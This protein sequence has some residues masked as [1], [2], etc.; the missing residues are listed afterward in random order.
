M[1]VVIPLFGF[2]V[3]GGI[4]LLV[5]LGN[6]LAGRGHDVCFAV[7]SDALESPFPVDASVKV[8]RIRTPM[9][10][11]YLDR[12]CNALLL[13]AR[14]PRCD[15][16]LANAFLTAYPACGAVLLGRARAGA[17]FA[18][19][20]EPLVMGGLSERTAAARKVV[21]A[22]ARLTY[23]LPLAKMAL[24]EWIREQL[25]TRH[26]VESTVVPPFINLEAFRPRKAT[27][28]KWLVATVG[29]GAAWK[30][31][32][33]LYEAM[34]IVRGK[35]PEARL[36]VATREELQVPG[37]VA[38][39]V[40]NPSSDEALAEIYAGCGIFAFPSWYEGFGLPPLEAMA[41]GTPVVLTDSGGVRDFADEGRNC[42]VV[43]ARKPEALAA[44][45]VELLESE[46][47]RERLG[48][49]GVE[50]ARSYTL[51]RMVSSAERLFEAQLR[52][53]T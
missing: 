3:S 26:G 18:L 19:H 22:V 1:K 52:E 33:D 39:E 35:H 8:V 25:R 30:G 11:R 15:V 38:A 21:G 6:G 4:R 27:R 9:P 51:D 50:T 7:A 47:L 10:V 34:R 44:G 42:L 13:G 53:L 28:D 23:H 2:N 48:R 20:Y 29:R 37:D 5:G 31:M 32:G 46:S 12:L 14:L 40:V 16:V 49:A 43:P 36:V 17:Y 45:I 24:S 41:C